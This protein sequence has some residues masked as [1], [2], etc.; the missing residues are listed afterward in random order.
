MEKQFLFNR[1]SPTHQ[2]DF[3]LDW[4]ANSPNAKPSATITELGNSINEISGGYYT[5]LFVNLLVD[6]QKI[7]DELFEGKYISIDNVDSI[8]LKSYGV[9]P[10]NA[11]YSIT[12][13]GLDFDLHGGYVGEQLRAENAEQAKAIQDEIIATQNTLAGIQAKAAT[14]NVDIQ[15]KIV[16]LNTWLVIAAVVAAAYY[17]TQI[18]D[19]LAKF[20]FCKS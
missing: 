20:F 17:L 2:L 13:K 6:I 19:W 1:L 11:L 5:E 3:V 14:D 15:N 16:Y 10:Q 7:V 9:I 18:F 8:S 12:F 4:F